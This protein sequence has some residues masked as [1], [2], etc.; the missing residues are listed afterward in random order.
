[1]RPAFSVCMA[2][3]NGRAF[4]RD[5]L[6]SIFSELKDADELIIVDDCSSDGTPD[7]IAEVLASTRNRQCTFVRLDTNHGHQ[8]A[9]LEA[10]AL[11]T[12]PLVALSDQDD[13]WPQGRLHTMADLLDTHSVALTFGS[14]RTFAFS[15]SIHLGNPAL[16]LRGRRGLWRFLMHRTGIPRTLYAFGSACA[17]RRSRVDLSRPMTTETHEQWLICMGLLTGGVHFSPQVVTFRRLH[18]NNQTKRRPPVQRIA[19]LGRESREMA[20]IMRPVL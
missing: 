8:R 20:R 19:A 5:Q 4:V 15:K 16:T 14:L 18:S 7:V 17:F 11:A 10:I 2:T 3:Y 6:V 12:N 9:F 13:V 1:M